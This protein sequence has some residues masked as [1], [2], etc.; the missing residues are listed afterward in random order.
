MSY[1]KTLFSVL[2]CICILSCASSKDP[3]KSD[4]ETALSKEG[5]KTQTLGSSSDKT[6]KTDPIYEEYKPTVLD[7]KDI[8][9]PMKSIKNLDKMIESYH[10]G[11]DL[12][13]EQVNENKRLKQRIIRGTFDI[14]ELCR[15]S[16]GK[17]WHEISKK[18]QKH[19]V[20]LMTT[21]LETK[22]IFSKEQLKGS[23]KYY[24]LRYKKEVFDDPEKKKATVYTNMNIPKEKMTLDITYKMLLT[25][26]GWKIFDIIVDDASLLTN[27]KSQFHRIII[28]D[29][30][31]ELIARME[32]KLKE[33]QGTPENKSATN[34][35][36]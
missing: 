17:H 16:L 22:A 6:K 10:L 13:P 9:P 2:L 18:Q 8:I 21:L 26:Y 32:K 28:K 35:K 24:T 36:Q 4:Q 25:P 31:K 3:N 7:P 1:L 27:Y 5:Q 23:N 11:Q 19:F 29:N 15:L 12:T 14:K 20:G 33:I 34:S 30:Y